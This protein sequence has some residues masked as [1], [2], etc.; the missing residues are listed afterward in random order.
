MAFFL[1]QIFAENDFQLETYP[2][3]RAIHR[4]FY[5]HSIF[6]PQDDVEK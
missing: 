3:Q 2:E 1:G 6:Y 4:H 5:G